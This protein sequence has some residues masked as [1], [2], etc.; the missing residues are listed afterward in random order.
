MADPV[1]PG[2]AP[3]QSF[4]AGAHQG[5]ITLWEDG[6][7][8]WDSGLAGVAIPTVPSFV[9]CGNEHMYFEIETDLGLRLIA[10]SDNVTEREGPFRLL[11][12]SGGV[13]AYGSLIE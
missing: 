7:Y 5:V 6:S 1:V 12:H 4:V 13:A 8:A 11:R 2:Y 3:T 9:G 10:W